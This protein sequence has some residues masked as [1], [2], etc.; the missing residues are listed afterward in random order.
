MP[1]IGRA[2]QDNE[3]LE[4][5][6]RC[7]GGKTPG[8]GRAGRDRRRIRLALAVPGEES[9]VTE[10]AEMVF[11]DPSP[12]VSDEDNPARP[13]RGDAE[14]CGIE[15]SP[16][17]VG[18]ERVQGEVPPSGILRPVV[19]KGHHGAPAVGLHVAPQGRD[20]ETPTAADRRH[21]TV[22]QAGGNRLEPRSLQRCNHDGR[23]EGG[24]QVDVGNGAAHDG[25]THAAPDEA[26]AARPARRLQGVQDGS[27]GRI[28]QP[29]GIRQDDLRRRAG[30]AGAPNR[31]WERTRS[32]PAVAPQMKRSSWVM[33]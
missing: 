23:L 21:R 8:L 11:S 4:D 26:H 19:G 20:L 10:D 18:V 25:V 33:A 32:I 17:A 15:H 9:E 22:L 2:Q 12:R 27:R 30:H 29:P 28:F 1:G 16:A 13:G 6:F 3:F 5:A 24:R 31:R 14:A 7:E